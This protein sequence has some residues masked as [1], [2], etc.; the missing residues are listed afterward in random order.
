MS[1]CDLHSLYSAVGDTKPA[2]FHECQFLLGFHRDIVF[3]VIVDGRLDPETVLSSVQSRP[4]LCYSHTCLVH[5]VDA[6]ALGQVVR[7]QLQYSKH[8]STLSPHTLPSKNQLFTAI[9]RNQ[10]L[11]PFLERGYRISSITS[12]T[13]SASPNQQ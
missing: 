4:F 1:K 9:S 10:I 12:P 13:I 2:L 7:I 8:T 11:Q 6:H 5:F 3:S